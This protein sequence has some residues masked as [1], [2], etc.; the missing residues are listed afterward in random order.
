MTTIARL[1]TRS[2]EAFLPLVN[3]ATRALVAAQLGG[4]PNRDRSRLYDR[5]QVP[6]EVPGY[7]PGVDYSGFVLPTLKRAGA[8]GERAVASSSPQDFTTPT[9]RRFGAELTTIL[10]GRT[11]D[12]KEN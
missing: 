10:R 9:M 6:E 5:L 1:S 2:A 3:A 11:N 7:E 12:T 4:N 8:L